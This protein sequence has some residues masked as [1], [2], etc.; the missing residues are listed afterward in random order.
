MRL[1]DGCRIRT[2][3]VREGMERR[4]EVAYRRDLLNETDK[5]SRV[6]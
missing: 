6:A 5:Y 4:I 2:F 1:K 3:F